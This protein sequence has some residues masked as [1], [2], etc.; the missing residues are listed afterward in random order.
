MHKIISVDFNFELALFSVFDQ[1]RQLFS[2]KKEISRKY[3]LHEYS[4]KLMFKEK[5]QNQFKSQ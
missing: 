2:I 5:E 1:S 4:L 3:H